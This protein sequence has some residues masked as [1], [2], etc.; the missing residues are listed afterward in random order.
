MNIMLLFLS[1]YKKEK[2][3]KDERGA[4]ESVYTSVLTC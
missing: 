1:D 4:E 3:E 2:G